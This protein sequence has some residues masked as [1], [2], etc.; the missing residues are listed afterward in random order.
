MIFTAC[1]HVYRPRQQ[2]RNGFKRVRRQCAVFVYAQTSAVN[3]IDSLNDAYFESFSE[4]L[5]A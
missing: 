2:I 3:H 1:F 4:D 5:F